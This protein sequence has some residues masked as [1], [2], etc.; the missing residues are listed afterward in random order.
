MSNRYGP[1][2]GVTNHYGNVGLGVTGAVIRATTST[3]QY[4]PGYLYGDLTAAD[5]AKEIQGLIVTPPSTGAFFAFEDGS[6]NWT[7]MTNGTDSFTYRLRENGVDRGTAP[8]TR[9]VGAAAATVSVAAIGLVTGIVSAAAVVAGAPTAATVAVAAT[10]IVLGIVS[11]TAVVISAAAP[12]SNAEM[13]QMFGWVSDLARIH[14]LILGQPL[15]V[16]PTQRSAG[17]VVQT[18]SEAGTTVTV[19][20]Q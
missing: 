4:G 12:L 1:V 13:R 5:D 17:A 9:N 10:G 18:I 15:V 3:G 14:G 11:A 8:A 2:Q 16:T 6:F 20:L 7:G 19:A